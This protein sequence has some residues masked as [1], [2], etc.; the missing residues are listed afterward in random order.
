MIA[1]LNPTSIYLSKSLQSSDVGL[2]FSCTVA[3]RLLVCSTARP[4]DPLPLSVPR[5]HLQALPVPAAA[6][7]KPSSPRAGL[8][9]ALVRD[10]TQRHGAWPSSS[11]AR[12]E[13]LHYGP[14]RHCLLSSLRHAGGPL[15]HKGG[16][17]FRVYWEQHGQDRHTSSELTW[18]PHWRMQTLEYAHWYGILPPLGATTIILYGWSLTATRYYRRQDQQYIIYPAYC[19]DHSLKLEPK[20]GIGTINIVTDPPTRYC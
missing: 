2:K 11:A 9:R 16:S 1:W 3:R 19:R 12:V 18:Y 14:F 20:V 7:E 8:P 6:P 15:M 5:R 10:T 4:P 13:H 17:K